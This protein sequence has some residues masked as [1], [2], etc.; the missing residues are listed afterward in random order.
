MPT[1]KNK[2]GILVRG[3]TKC[4]AG[5]T[6]LDQITE[7]GLP[8]GLPCS[9]APRA[10][11]KPCWLSSF[12]FAEPPSSVNQVCLCHSKKPARNSPRMSPPWGLILRHSA[13]ARSCVWILFVLSAVRYQESGTFDL[14]DL[15]SPGNRY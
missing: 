3:I 10:A 13:H 5:I 1:R 6:G 7:G 8:D 14:G 2:P 11:A 4:P 15:H 12:W 9:A